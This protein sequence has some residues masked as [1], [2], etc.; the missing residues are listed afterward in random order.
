MQPFHRGSVALI[1]FSLIAAFFS[2][3]PLA[4]AQT[5]QPTG[6]SEWAI[7]TNTNSTD[8][9][10]PRPAVALGTVQED[11]PLPADS[12]AF[13]RAAPVWGYAGIR[14]YALGDHVAPNG[15][16][17]KPLFDIEMNFNFSSSKLS[18][19]VEVNARH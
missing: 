4:I 17:F 16:E 12:Q 18:Y 9:W 5:S 8:G 13:L 11:V 14:G 10:L 2:S 3:A 7:S 1:I 15:V 6:P 19:V